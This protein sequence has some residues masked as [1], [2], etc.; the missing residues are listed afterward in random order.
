MVNAPKIL[1]Y[2]LLISLCWLISCK[3]YDNTNINKNT[4]A[5]YANQSVNAVNKKVPPKDD[6]IELSKIISLPYA[7]EEAVWREEPPAAQANVNRTAAR[8]IT[9]VLRYTDEDAQK[10][11]EQAEKYQPGTQAIINT[12]DWFPAELVAQSQLSGDETLKG[13][14]YPA[15]DFIQQPF[16]NGRIVRINDTNYF[17]LELI[18]N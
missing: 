2:L 15:N 7:P 9:A 13:T 10:I 4:N 18:A 8:K 12:E 17:I 1:T 6:A 3:E 11:V 5:A 14:A 16:N